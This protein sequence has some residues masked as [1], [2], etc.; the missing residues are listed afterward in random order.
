M[1]SSQYITI[2]RYRLVALWLNKADYEMSACNR[3]NYMAD[4]KSYNFKLENISREVLE[5]CLQMS[6]Y[7][8][9]YSL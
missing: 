4:Y 9:K 2:K 6:S 7:F 3:S 8:K 1:I 5:K